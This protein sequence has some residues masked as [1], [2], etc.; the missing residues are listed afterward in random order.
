M[1]EKVEKIDSQQTVEI[2][3]SEIPGE[4]KNLIGREC[5]WIEE[6][7]CPDLSTLRGYKWDGKEKLEQVT[8]STWKFIPTRVWRVLPEIAEKIEELKSKERK[9][10][11]IGEQTWT[12]FLGDCDVN[13]WTWTNGAEGD[14][15]E[16]DPTSDSDFS[17]VAPKTVNWGQEVYITDDIG[18]G[19]VI[20]TEIDGDF[21]PLDG[22][23]FASEG[24]ARKYQKEEEEEQ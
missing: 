19:Y 12:E 17:I 18:T 7:I 5:N 14:I 9:K 10:K 15:I 1:D 13:H 16:A 8:G 24:E 20:L 6:G 23:I 3:F 21:V 2:P 4:V 11:G 22:R